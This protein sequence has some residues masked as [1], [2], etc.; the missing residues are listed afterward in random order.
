[1]KILTK[2]VVIVSSLIFLLSCQ[3]EDS[4]S[5]ILKRKNLEPNLEKRAENYVS[6]GGGIL[7]KMKGSQGGNFEF[8]T[9]NVLWRASLKTLD[10]IPIQSAN[11][12]GG[13][14][15]TD[16]YSG[17]LDSNSSIKIEVRF[18]STELSPSSI[19]VLSYKRTCKNMNCSTAKL[20]SNFSSDI[21]LKILNNAREIS[22]KEKSKKKK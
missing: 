17:S 7:N 4:N 21:K 3:K 8:A 5:K 6:E 1:M 13:V 15:V 22:I 18:K 2:F 14:L 11:Y 9:A 20:E 10:F 16:W 19:D 12:S